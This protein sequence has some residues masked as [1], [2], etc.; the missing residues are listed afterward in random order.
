MIYW[1]L[2]SDILVQINLYIG[3]YTGDIQLLVILLVIYCSQSDY[4]IYWWYTGDILVIYWWYISKNYDSNI[5]PM[6]IIRYTGDILVQV[7]Y[8]ITGDMLVIYW[9][10]QIIVLL[11]LNFS[12][13]TLSSYWH[14]IDS[15][16]ESFTWRCIEAGSVPSKACAAEGCVSEQPKAVSK[17]P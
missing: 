14:C 13:H 1:W 8:D 16:K 17:T 3:N 2:L 12:I 7:I 5:G 15:M 9:W 10:L 4:Q 6:V 11:V